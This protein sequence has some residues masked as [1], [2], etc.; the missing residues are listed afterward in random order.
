V[1][2]G[3]S[4]TLAFNQGAPWLGSEVKYARSSTKVRGMVARGLAG[5]SRG[6]V[7]HVVTWSHPH[8]LCFRLYGEDTW[9]RADAGQ[10]P[11]FELEHKELFVIKG[12]PNHIL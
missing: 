2:R 4:P 6:H 12:L 5:C 3:F 11:N 7:G 8:R 10:D 9:A 1:A